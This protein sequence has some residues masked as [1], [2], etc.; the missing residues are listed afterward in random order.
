MCAPLSEH[1]TVSFQ[2]AKNNSKPFSGPFT[3]IDTLYFNIYFV[4]ISLDMCYC[5]CVARRAHVKHTNRWELVQ[6]LAAPIFNKAITKQ[7]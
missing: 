5:V 6:F 7:F 3:N 2:A 4:E 1:Q